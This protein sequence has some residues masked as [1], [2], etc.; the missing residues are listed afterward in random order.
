MQLL[1]SQ[2]HHHHQQP[3]ALGM[4]SSQFDKFFFMHFRIRTPFAETL[5]GPT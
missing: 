1:R 3:K 2:K 5:N 4:F